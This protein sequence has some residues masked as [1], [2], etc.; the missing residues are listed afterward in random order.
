MHL[1]QLEKLNENRELYVELIT[2]KFNTRREA[3]GLIPFKVNLKVQKSLVLSK[4]A[5]SLDNPRTIKEHMELEL[6]LRIVEQFWSKQLTKD[7]MKLVKTYRRAS[8]LF[9]R[10]RLN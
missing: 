5:F 3:L 7:E 6:S 9:A 8:G 4:T 2:E 10:V 1:I